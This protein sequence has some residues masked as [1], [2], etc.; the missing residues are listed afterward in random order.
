MKKVPLTLVIYTILQWTWGILQNI[1][2][3]LLFLFLLIKNPKAKHDY[4]HGA[5]VTPW[6]Q[7]KGSMG[8]GMF[9]FFGHQGAP[10]AK[11]V[12][13][14]EWG[15]TV[16]SVILGPLFLFVIGLPSLIW[17][18]TPKFEKMRKEKNIPYTAAYC[19]KWASGMGERLTGEPAVWR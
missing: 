8:L 12:I 5:V 6:K 14:H 7:G 11:E 16:Q 1:L 18:Y 4:Y 9:I 13:V 17:A 2:G 15:H 19:E 3:G 10:D